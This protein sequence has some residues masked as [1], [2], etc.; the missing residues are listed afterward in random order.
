MKC[1]QRINLSA[2]ISAQL[3]IL[4]FC[5]EEQKRSLLMDTQPCHTL[6]NDTSIPP[7]IRSLAYASFF[8][9]FLFVFYI[10]LAALGW[11]QSM[12]LFMPESATSHHTGLHS[13]LEERF[14]FLPVFFSSLCIRSTQ[15]QYGILGVW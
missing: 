10:F 11:P 14:L 12:S 8:V 5:L 2:N 13:N 9:F 3:I 15:I 7:V 4:C 6:V 1:E